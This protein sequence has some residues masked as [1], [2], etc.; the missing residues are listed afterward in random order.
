MA[1]A[2]SGAFST[3][4]PR[5]VEL[6][7]NND[8]GIRPIQMTYGGEKY[9]V[10]PSHFSS[11][12]DPQIQWWSDCEFEIPHPG[13]LVQE[14]NR[15]DELIREK[16]AVYPLAVQNARRPEDN[17]SEVY[18]GLRRDMDDRLHEIFTQQN[19]G[20]GVPVVVCG[21][22]L[23]SPAMD[24]LAHRVQTFGRDDLH[25]YNL[26]VLQQLTDVAL[27][28]C[29]QKHTIS[30]AEFLEKISEELEG[31]QGGPSAG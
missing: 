2:L 12:F 30:S 15:F 5:L 25:Q 1:C 20:R 29:Y 10:I 18:R 11:L 16:S 14:W 6:L 13:H 23:S 17:M 7:E 27:V 4:I 21:K 24:I 8:C 3:L 26:S 28:Q 9:P 31:T 19:Y 22:T